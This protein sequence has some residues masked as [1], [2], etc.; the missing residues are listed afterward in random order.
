MRRTAGSSRRRGYNVVANAGGKKRVKKIE[1]KSRFFLEEEE[2]AKP[3]S[4][5]AK[6]K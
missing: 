4:M 2:I 3:K 6:K 5:K 1:K